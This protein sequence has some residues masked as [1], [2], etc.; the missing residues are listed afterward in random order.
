VAVVSVAEFLLGVLCYQASYHYQSITHIK[1][2]NNSDPWGMYVLAMTGQAIARNSKII[3]TCDPF[4]MCGPGTDE[5]LY[6]TAG[7][8]VMRRWW[9][10]SSMG[11][12]LWR[13]PG[14]P[15]LGPGSGLP[16]RG[17]AGHAT[18]RHHREKANDIGL[19]LLDK[20]K[21]TFENPKRGNSSTRCTM[22]R[23]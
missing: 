10:S 8:T 3:S 18:G 9:A 17:G 7:H 2:T 23:A 12:E 16:G 6:E 1:W 11:G 21:E 5:L 20:Y 22:S 4:T 19:K 15:Q 14:G 13:Q